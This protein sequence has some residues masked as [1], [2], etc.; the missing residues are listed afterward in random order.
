MEFGFNTTENIVKFRHVAFEIRR[1]T[2]RHIY[3]GTENSRPENMAQSKLQDWK[4]QDWKTRN[5]KTRHQTAGLEN[6]RKGMYGKP[7]LLQL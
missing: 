3:G 6:A 1:R 5:W 2:D 7:N 4:T